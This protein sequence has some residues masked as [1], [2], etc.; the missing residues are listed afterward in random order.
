MSSPPTMPYVYSSTPPST[1]SNLLNK[2]K[3][4]FQGT[5]YPLMIVVAVIAIV[6]V[7][8]FVVI[9]VKKG[10]L[11]SVNLLNSPIVTAN[12]L[13]GEFNVSPGAKLPDS[14][15]GN[16]FSMSLWVFV[17]NVSI[18][19]T[20]KIIAYRGSQESYSNGKFFVY[21][22]AKT[23]S[24]YASVRTNGALEETSSTNEPSLNDIKNNKYFLQSVIDYVPLQRWV[25]ITYTIKDTV[26]STFVDGDLYSVTSVYE[27]PTN[28]NGS[29]PIPVKQTGD[30]M[31]AGKAGKEGFNGY[32]GNG[33]YYNFALTV[34]EAKLIY[35]KGPY[36][37]SWL[38]YI[39]LGNLGV[40]APIY[41]IT[42]ADLK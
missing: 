36:T 20:H 6:A 5:P 14:S 40:R 29:R 16:E 19:N 25:N 34:K 26:M 10:S 7:V 27:L 22:D 38:S 9:R 12:P 35:N 18:T 2:F 3:S 41:R 31:I 30:V 24:L 4:M 33:T 32:I 1:S 15:N 23:N 17:D 28:P 42:S 37:V 21:M 8:V 11:K 39:G 13:S